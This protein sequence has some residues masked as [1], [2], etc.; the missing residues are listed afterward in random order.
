MTNPADRVT[1]VHDGRLLTRDFA[2]VTLA[3]GFFMLSFGA[4]LPV[5][6]RY[7]SNELGGSDLAVGIVVGSYAVSAIALRPLVGRLGDSRGR[8][9]LFVGGACLTAVGMAAHIPA[10]SV[11]LLIGARLLIGAGQGA[12]FVGATTLVN[13]LAPPDRR[14]EAASWFST[15][16]YVGLGLGPFIGEALLSRASFDAV[17]VAVTVGMV[18]AALIGLT[19]PKGVPEVIDDGWTPE[20]RTGLA[21]LLHPTGVGPGVIVFLGAMGFIGFNTFVPLY[22]EE[23]GM[24]DVAGVFLLFSAVVLVVRLLGR[25]LPDAY[26]PVVV[27]SVALAASSMGLL[28]VGALRS[29]VGLYLFTI[30]LGFGSALLYPALMAA[31]VNAAH[32]RERS[33]VIATFTLFFEFAS[34]AG[35][36]VLGIVASQTSYAGAFVAAACFALAGLVMLHLYLRPKLEVGSVHV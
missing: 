1:G 32:E 33:A 10:D 16:I 26:G 2:L 3:T 20:V 30:V 21:R 13:D 8:R 4:T 35:G 11:G 17:W 36:A 7:V 14:G 18:I 28:G 34:V 6:P 23:L 19:M 27:G 12:A 9:L 25:K 22:G 29:I 15:A 24:S 31:A 5:L